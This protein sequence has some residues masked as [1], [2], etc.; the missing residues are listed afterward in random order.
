[1]LGLQQVALLGGGRNFWE[2]RGPPKG[3][4]TMR[5]AEC[6]L[7]PL[8]LSG[9]PLELHTGPCSSAPSLPWP[10]PLSSG[11]STMTFS[12]I[13]APKQRLN[14]LSVFLN[15]SNSWRFCFSHVLTLS[16]QQRAHTTNIKSG[17]HHAR[18]GG[19]RL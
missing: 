5:P 15:K 6:V 13:S 3:E 16:R 7:K 11:L 8:G 19:T 14:N 2:E 9:P 10:H 12:S 17:K 4:G 1:M 18:R